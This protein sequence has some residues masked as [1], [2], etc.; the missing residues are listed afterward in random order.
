MAQKRDN[1]AVTE[2]LEKLNKSSA[3]TG[4]EVVFDP[5]TGELVVASNP[6]EVADGT[7]ITSIAEDGFASQF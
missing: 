4:N 1:K 2:E 7:T 5:R 3:D 6:N